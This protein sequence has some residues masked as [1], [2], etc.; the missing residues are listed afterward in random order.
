MARRS[1]VS[2]M[3]LLRDTRDEARLHRQL[4]GGEPFDAALVG[5]A[6][7]GL[8]RLQHGGDFPVRSSLRPYASRRGRPASASA[9][10]LSCAIGSCSRI[11]PLKIHTLTPQVP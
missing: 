8:H 3:A 1:P 6:E 10:F 4:S 9:I 5:L 7:L 2:S 11:S